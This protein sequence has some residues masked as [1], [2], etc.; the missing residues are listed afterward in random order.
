MKRIALMVVAL[1]G[2]EL[3]AKTDTGH[4]GGNCYG[5]HTCDE[6]LV[7][8]QLLTPPNASDVDRCVK[9]DKIRI[10]RMVLPVPPVQP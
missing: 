9:R 1:A 6:G 3:N 5:N 2:C 4:E 10:D 7:C 8:A